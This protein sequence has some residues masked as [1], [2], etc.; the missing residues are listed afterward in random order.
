MRRFRPIDLRQKRE[1]KKARSLKNRIERRGEKEG[2][3]P[4][5]MPG[6]GE[7]GEKLSSS[8]TCRIQDS[9]GKKK[10]GSRV[11]FSKN[12]KK[13]GGILPRR[14]GEERRASAL[15]FAKRA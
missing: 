11:N 3:C 9:P 12:H 15:L 2:S 1:E 8:T 14:R 7:G 13:T 10:K 4:T 6:G 5:T